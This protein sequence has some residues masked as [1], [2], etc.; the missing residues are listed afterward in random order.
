MGRNE[1]K[2]RMRAQ[3]KEDR[4]HPG[5]KEA[6]EQ[7]KKDVQEALAQ[8][9]EENG[10]PKW[11]DKSAMEHHCPVCQTP[12]LKPNAKRTCVKNG[13]VTPC[14]RYHEG[15]MRP[16]DHT[17]TAC[18]QEMALHDKRH[19]AIYEV[20]HRARS[21][22]SNTGL[23]AQSQSGRG[24]RVVTRMPHRD[25]KK[26]PNPIRARLEKKARLDMK[27]LVNILHPPEQT[28]EDVILA[29][30]EDVGRI[31]GELINKLHSDHSDVPSHEL[32]KSQFYLHTLVQDDLL[33]ESDRAVQADRRFDRYKKTDWYTK[34]AATNTAL[35]GDREHSRLPSVLPIRNVYADQ[36]DSG[37]GKLT[38]QIPVSAISSPAKSTVKKTAPP[39]SKP[40]P[41]TTK[42]ATA[43]GKNTVGDPTPYF[44]ST[45]SPNSSHPTLSQKTYADVVASPPSAEAPMSP[46]SDPFFKQGR[47]SRQSSA[48]S[49]VSQK[50]SIASSPPPPSKADAV[51][52]APLPATTTAANDLQ[53]PLTK[54][55]K[56]KAKKVR[57]KANKA[58][59]KVDAQKEET[60][61]ARA[62]A[63][64]QAVEEEQK[65]RIAELQQ[66]VTSASD[67][68]RKFNYGLAL[69]FLDQYKPGSNAMFFELQTHMS[70]VILYDPAW[71][72]H[73]NR[74][75]TML[76][77]LEVKYCYAT[78][79][80]AGRDEWTALK[81]DPTKTEKLINMP[82]SE[83]DDFSSALGA[84]AAWLVGWPPEQYFQSNI[85]LSMAE[86]EDDD[87]VV[88]LQAIGDH[89]LRAAKLPNEQGLCEYVRKTVLVRT[90]LEIWALA[91]VVKKQEERMRL[92]DGLW[93]FV[94]E[95]FAP[96]KYAGGKNVGQAMQFEYWRLVCAG[97]L[98]MEFRQHLAYRAKGKK[99]GSA[100]APRKGKGKSSTAMPVG[101]SGCGGASTG[102]RN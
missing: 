68:L 76:S 24:L 91:G 64:R 50:S 99:P 79:A 30:Q 2:A 40:T 94:G 43:S 70:A 66:A 85:Q 33:Q 17:C 69:G 39:K 88:K 16:N 95:H 63:A 38:V 26:G 77:G 45:S 96:P 67:E 98:S 20:F 31:M 49:Q 84:Y 80:L 28:K 62:V 72:A 53:R 22:T 58:A 23:S 54:A 73:F 1:K 19:K 4:C 27:T 46:F 78:M 102:V 93:D 61:L 89:L 34:D 60:L 11:G 12:L 37:G 25:G 86:P 65:R 90:G 3:A 36:A 32:L 29:P 48:S 71:K 8:R 51:E 14:P 87:P 59:A 92:E 101:V 21:L 10:A 52:A 35:Q 15:L 83:L 75:R 100:V 55:E 18:R 13:H 42:L 56:N 7:K 44:S 81:N 9:R 57:A 74:A 47:K 97:Q 6:R 41:N 82:A 5:A